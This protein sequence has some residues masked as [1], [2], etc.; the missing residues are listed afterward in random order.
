MSPGQ[1]ENGDEKTVGRKCDEERMR[2]RVGRKEGGE[3]ERRGGS[4]ASEERADRQGG[5]QGGRQLTGSEGEDNES[6]TPS[7]GP[8]PTLTSRHLMKFRNN[9]AV[10]I[11]SN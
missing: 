9:Y 8:V 10:A 5:Q 7:L 6:G 1:L 4:V 3:R 2:G 11:A